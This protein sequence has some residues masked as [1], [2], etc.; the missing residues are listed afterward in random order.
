MCTKRTYCVTV[1]A[2]SGSRSA[3]WQFRRF[4]LDKVLLAFSLSLNIRVANRSALCRGQEP[5]NREK[6]VSE[7]KSAHCPSPQ[8]RAFRVRKSPFSMWC[9]PCREMGIFWPK[10][11]FLGWGEDLEVGFFFDSET[12]FFPV[13]GFWFLYRA[14][15]FATLRVKKG[16]EKSVPAV[17]VLLSAPG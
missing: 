7:S 13:L 14:D 5:Q 12:L 6:R 8:K 4:F 11:P 17:P 2:W 10:R 3:G 9:A 1:H 16:A 15:G